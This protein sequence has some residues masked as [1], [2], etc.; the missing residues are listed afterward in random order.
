MLHDTINQAAYMAQG[1]CLLWKPWLVAMHAGSDFLIALSYSAIGL[2]VW[3]FVKKREDFT[4]KPLAI[5]FAAFIFFCGLSHLAQA[6]TLWWPVY[7]TQAAIKLVTAAA[8]A[9]A[10]FM[11]F[12]LIPKALAIPS[13]KQ[14]STAND[15]LA[16]EIAA[17]RRTL[18]ELERT[19]RELERRVSERTKELEHAKARFQAL[20][21]AS[22]Q[23]VW[24]CD[25]N[26]EVQEDSPSWRL[27]TGQSIYEFLSGKWI[28]AIHLDDRGRALSAWREA[29]RSKRLYSVEYRLRHIKH[30]Y[31]WTEARASRS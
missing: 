28:N 11:I 1:N 10:A 4:L 24:T 5:L 12:P 22:A 9:A 21:N 18:A 13:P 26:G 7:E 29:V 20:V 6:A 2:A 3:I 23:V 31:R 27:F 16:A 15:D 14:L 8:S 25:P 17:H 30:G 19:K